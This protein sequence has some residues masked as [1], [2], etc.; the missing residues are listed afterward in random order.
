MKIVGIIKLVKLESVFQSNN[1]RR[2]NIVQKVVVVTG[3]D[4]LKHPK[5]AKMIDIVNKDISATID[6]ARTADTI[7]IA[8]KENIVD[9]T[10]VPIRNVVKV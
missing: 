2:I 10:D 3:I 7:F 1:A 6:I 4:A 5:F 9:Y 8:L